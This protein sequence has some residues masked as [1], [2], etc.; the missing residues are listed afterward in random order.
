[1]TEKKELILYTALHL[2]AKEG[3]DTTPTSKIARQAGVSEGLIFRH[4][5]S[6]EGLMD[7]VLNLGETKIKP[8]IDAL[9]WIEDPRERIQRIVE[10]TYT[11]Y[12]EEREFWQLQFTVKWQRRYNQEHKKQSLY[13]QKLLRIGTEAFR[14]LG[15][16]EPEKE[17]VLLA[18]LMEGFGNLM[19]SEADP[20]VI[21]NTLAFIKSKY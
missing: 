14:E 19:I 21:E 10:L 1:M 20:V 3:F 18:M 7:A 9:E 2:F 15:Y 17:I 16:A 8:H 6:K 13:Y 5:G 11:L 12:C 4:F